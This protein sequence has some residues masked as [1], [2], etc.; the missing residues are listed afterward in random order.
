MAAGGEQGQLFYR[1]ID[2]PHQMIFMN[3]VTES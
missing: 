3:R 1:S 2:F